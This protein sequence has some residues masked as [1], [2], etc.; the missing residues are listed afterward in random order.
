MIITWT[1]WYFSLTFPK[2]KSP[3]CGINKNIKK[4]NNNN[5]RK[6]KRRKEARKKGRKKKKE[7]VIFSKWT[8]SCNLLCLIMVTNNWDQSNPCRVILKGIL[9]AWRRRTLLLTFDTMAVNG[10]LKFIFLPRCLG[11]QLGKHHATDMH[12]SH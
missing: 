1:F 5:K 9:I 4:Q 6:K 12:G 8:G 3:F 2:F 7:K 11:L 10:I